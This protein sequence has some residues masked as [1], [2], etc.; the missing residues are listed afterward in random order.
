MNLAAM[1]FPLGTRMHQLRQLLARGSSVAAVECST[2]PHHI[3]MW[4]QVIFMAAKPFPNHA[5]HII[6]AIGAF[7][8]FFAHHQPQPRMVQTIV[9]G[10]GNLQQLAAFAVF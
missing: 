8:G 1:P 9:A 10:L 4:R 5:L 6:A 2:Y 3:I 7:G